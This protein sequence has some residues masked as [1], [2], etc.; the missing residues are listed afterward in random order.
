MAVLVSNRDSGKTHH[1]P[2]QERLQSG[3]PREDG[4]ME[5]SRCLSPKKGLQKVTTHAS[6]SPWLNILFSCNLQPLRS[7]GSG[8]A[9]SALCSLA[10]GAQAVCGLESHQLPEVHS[11][12]VCFI[13]VSQTH[14]RKLSHQLWRMRANPA[15]LHGFC[16]HPVQMTFQKDV[17]SS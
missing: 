11:R 8:G 12:E 17:D 13:G 7:A 6:P 3:P 4:F 9:V 2:P 10:C 15:P 16:P 14:K 5:L 1:L